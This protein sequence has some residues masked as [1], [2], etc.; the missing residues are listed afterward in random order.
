MHQRPDARLVQGKPEPSDA[1]TDG[2]LPPADEA[3]IG[4]VIPE[5]TSD[6]A[7]AAFNT[8]LIVTQTPE[9]LAEVAE[10]L[11]MLRKK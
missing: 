8:K 1:F 5:A 10:L 6:A 11:E 7:I 4:A 2:G 9:R 3:A